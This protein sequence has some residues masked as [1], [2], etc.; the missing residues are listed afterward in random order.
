MESHPVSTAQSVERN[1]DFV[2]LIV[3]ASFGKPARCRRVE[4]HLTD[5]LSLDFVC[6]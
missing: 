4:I 6:K 1:R 3:A 2:V 5:N